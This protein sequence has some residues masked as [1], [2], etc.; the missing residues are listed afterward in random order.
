MSGGGQDGDGTYQMLPFDDI[1]GSDVLTRDENEPAADPDSRA[2]DRIQTANAQVLWP[3]EP[4]YSDIDDD[5]WDTGDL[6]D[7]DWRNR[8]H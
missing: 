8:L 6:D 2:D 5:M 1:S 3:V 7:D 4:T